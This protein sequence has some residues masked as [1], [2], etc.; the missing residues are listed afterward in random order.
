VP[1]YPAGL[2]KLVRDAPADGWMY[3]GALENRPALIRRLARVRPLWGNPAEVLRL[4]RNPCALADALRAAGLNCPHVWRRSGS[5]PPG[6]TWLRKPR[7]SAGGTRIAFAEPSAV[8]QGTS[9]RRDYLQQFVDGLPY[10]AVFVSAGRTAVLLAIT[11]QLI[12]ADWTGASGFRYCGSI[13]PL[14]VEDQLGATFIQIGNTLADRFGLVG[15]FGVDAIVNQHGVWPVEVNPRYTASMELVDWAR[16]ISAVDLHVQACQLG[17]LPASLPSRSSTI[18][19]KAIAFA[20]RPLT[21]G[22][23]LAALAGERH[24]GGWPVVADIPEPG[25][26]I[27][28]G[29]PIVTLLA[30]GDD[31][32]QII[33]RLRERVA[34]VKRLLAGGRQ[35]A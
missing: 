19:G 13:G 6:A 9:N 35:H 31:E 17:Q 34:G 27:P 8:P 15:L 12:G 4:V 24:A 7:R 30:E 25:T 5:A 18:V 3:T 21:A 29:G 33:A 28:A 32:A 1:N 14:D 10:S 26:A 11:R 22:E 16:G 2:A 23:E 20:D